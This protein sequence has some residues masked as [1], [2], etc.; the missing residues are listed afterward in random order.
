MRNPIPLL[1]VLMLL[2]VGTLAHNLKG[3]V[4][5]K[6][7]Q[8]IPFATV[9]FKE[10][11]Q[12]TA[13]NEQGNFEID[14]PKGRYTLTCRS[15][16]FQPKTESITL[17]G[18]GLLLSIQLDEQVQELSEI[19]VH[20]GIDLALPIMRKVISLSYLH[21]NQV[22][23]YLAT[24]YLKG[25]LKV[26]NIPAFFRSQLKKQNITLQSGDVLVQESVSTIQFVAPE[27][28]NLEVKSIRSTF[29]KGIDFQATNMLGSSLYQDHIDAMIS[30]VGRSAF[31]H[32]DFKF[33]GFS[34]EGKQIVN[35]IRVTPKRKS[36]LLF[37]GYLWIMENDWCLKQAD[38]S[39]ETPFG[40]VHLYTTYDEV[41]PSVWLPVSH[42]FSFEAGMLG[43]KGNGQFST[44][45][46]YDELKLNKEVMA[47]VNKPVSQPMAA[48][49]P[50]AAAVVPA[51]KAK[52]AATS[53]KRLD[54]I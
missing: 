24:V 19:T 53:E 29:P 10:I 22:E 50:K 1:I 3:S 33:E 43:L 16:G 5:D 14:L 15:L 11:A 47:L 36:K 38:L 9:F 20:A 41:Q 32:Y 52:R 34:Y 6:N 17:T 28:Y 45:V 46:K 54:K 51:K 30:P 39:F 31:S 37:E 23:Q 8:P 35:K 40:T 21:L 4:K 2:S 12:G 18:K 26:E 25:T 48:E 27:K 7:G 44:S 42:R 13:A 49:T